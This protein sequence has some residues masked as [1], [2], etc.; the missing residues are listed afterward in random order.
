MASYAVYLYHRIILAMR[1]SFMNRVMEVR[2]GVRTAGILLRGYLARFP[3]R[4]SS[5]A[6]RGFYRPPG[7]GMPKAH[8]E[9]GSHLPGS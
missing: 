8:W 2:E 3:C 1:A 9:A 7:E 6:V 4:A 5:A